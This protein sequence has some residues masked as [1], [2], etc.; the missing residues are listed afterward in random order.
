MLM[1]AQHDLDFSSTPCELPSGRVPAGSCLKTSPA[2]S[3]ATKAET[4]LPWLEKWLGASLTYRPAAGKTPVLLS[5]R[6]GLSNGQLWMRNM[7]EW[8]HIP[9]QSR[10]DEGV[11]SLSEILETGPIDPRYFLNAKA[12]AGILRRA[13]KRG[14]ELPTALRRALQQVAEGLSDAEKPEDKTL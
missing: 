14:K 1:E 11:C 2:C 5:A 7:S 3:A 8:N 6:S 4:L 13:E 10:S 12:C 9:E